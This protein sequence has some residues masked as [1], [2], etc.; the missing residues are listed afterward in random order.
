MTARDRRADAQ[1]GNVTD[2]E[3][4]ERWANRN[5]DLIHTARSDAVVNSLAAEFAAVRAPLEQRIAQAERERD[6]ALDNAA[7]FCG[8]N[9]RLTKDRDA[10]AADYTM[11][12]RALQAAMGF[13][14]TPPHG[15]SA[16][17]VHWGI[18]RSD[19]PVWGYIAA[20]LSTSRARAALAAPKEEKD[21]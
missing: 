13:N 12:V 17:G 15:I 2:R 18:M 1:E 6:E 3:R 7:A 9:E 16:G 14:D 8:D 11:V 10:L 4:A 19:H 5:D 20:V 21:G